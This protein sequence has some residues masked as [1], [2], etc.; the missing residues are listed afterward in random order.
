M[1]TF[2]YYNSLGRENMALC[3][4]CGESIDLD[5][6][7]CPSCGRNKPASTRIFGI[8]LGPGLGAIVLVLILFYLFT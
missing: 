5:T 1:L 8:P 4:G 2:C 6:K 3:V 7:V